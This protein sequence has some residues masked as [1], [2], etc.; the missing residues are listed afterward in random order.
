MNTNLK[1][2]LLILIFLFTCNHIFSQKHLYKRFELADGL[3]HQYIYTLDQTKQGFLWIGTA[4]G[5]CRY[6][7]KTFVNY[8]TADSLTDN[9]VNTTFLDSKNRLW[10]GH[11]QGG[12]TLFDNVNFKK[13]KNTKLLDSRINKIYESKDHTIWICTQ[14]NDLLYIDSTLQIKKS[15]FNS[16]ILWDIIETSNG[17]MLIG[18]SEGVKIFNHFTNESVSIN[19]FNDMQIININQMDIDTYIIATE[20]DG[21]Y[22]LK[23][24][25]N[26]YEIKLLKENENS[27]SEKLVFTKKDNGGI[28]W[29]SKTE[30]GLGK[31]KIKGDSLI[32]IDL[33]N[34]K[35]GLEFNQFKSMLKDREG[36][37]WAGSFGN[38]L[39]E[40]SNQAFTTYKFKNSNIDDNINNIVELSDGEF[41]VSTSKG[42]ATFKTSDNYLVPFDYKKKWNQMN[43]EHIIGSC[44]DSKGNIY[45]ATKQN[46]I[47][48]INI[49]DNKLKV[50]LDIDSIQTKTNYIAIDK[51]DDIWLAT[52][53]GA[54]LIDKKSRRSQK[55]D[56]QNGLA[57]NVVYTIYVDSENN[58]WFATYG[59]G[60]SKFSNGECKTYSSPL[61]TA[62][63]IN[64]II[65]DPTKFIWLG[66]NGQGLIKCDKYGNLKSIYT[67]KDNLGSNFCYNLAI[68]FKN[69][70]LIGHK[71]G[72]SK[73]NLISSKLTY[74][75]NHDVLDGLE[76]N[77]NTLVQDKNNCIWYGTDRGLLKYD[78]NKDQLNTKEPI[79]NI[80]SLKLFFATPDW[81]KLNQNAGLLSPP[82]NV[83]FN[84]N[85]NHITFNYIGICLSA[86]EK[87]KYK[88]LL[89]GFDNT[90]SMET[91]ETSTTYSNLPPGN[92]TFELRSMN[93]DGLWNKQSV[94]YNFIITSPYWKT[95]LFYLLISAV[96]FAIVY[97]IFFLRTRAFKRQNQILESEKLKLENEIHE[98]KITEKKL[99]ESE[100]IIKTTNDELNNLIWR[101]YH[102]LRG[103]SS[104]IQGLTQIAMLDSILEKKDKYLLM[105][106]D[107]AFKMDTIVKDFFSVSDIKNNII[108]PEKI[109]LKYLI[110]EVITELSKKHITIPYVDIQINA[111]Y[112]LNLDKTLTTLILQ[113]IIDNAVLY[114]K[115]SDRIDIVIRQYKGQAKILI[116]DSGQG[117]PT[118]GVKRVFEMFYRASVNS[119]G[120]G[121][122]LYI[123]KKALEMLG[124]KI[125]IFTKEGVGTT[126]MVTLN[127]IN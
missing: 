70:L 100:Q 50:W 113:N 11:Y 71:N 54:Y 87:V 32:R 51:N 25:G 5:L 111:I 90:W 29:V 44:K 95:P 106:Q 40:L 62:I 123:V 2:Q 81:K 55:F 92:Y 35:T 58:A 85:N 36:N 15:S 120:N 24:I 121:L 83:T 84:H 43:N 79:T 76:M 19:Q 18:S 28:L 110:E 13:I 69:N 119:K 52:N 80:T 49:S 3:P 16:G 1:Y 73:I 37:L 75:S 74:I 63:N 115:K 48:K 109:I 34:A 107:T 61:I 47:Y 117:I 122:G 26:K 114:A 53:N 30:S 57:H 89:N 102:D 112:P 91:D 68:D 23:I 78:P 6:D 86:P 67:K 22:N 4:E 77:L 118:E 17:T 98:R 105:I 41:L 46:K 66:T 64:S 10:I 82:A 33:Y 124:G 127:A 108:K 56:M 97:T 60:I 7:G 104:T 72:I 88:Y 31:Y 9:F 39:Y 42:M 96:M 93:N 27:H 20:Y 45:L 8:T 116:I 103:P 14:N 59:S 12:I 101:S 21:I 126:V 38:G 125:H 99:K 94:K 65:E